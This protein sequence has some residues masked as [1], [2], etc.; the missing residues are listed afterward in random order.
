VK[1]SLA[2][3]R[4]RWQTRVALAVTIESGRIA[5]DLVRRENGGSRVVQSLVLPMGAE[6]IVA[7]PQ[8]AGEEFAAQLRAS[9]IRERR[10][11]VCIPAGWAITTATDLPGISPED[12]RSYLE[13]RAESE[14]P[15]PVADLRLAHCVYLLPD[16]KQRATVV[17]VPAKRIEAVERMLDTAGCRAVSRRGPSGV[18]R[19]WNR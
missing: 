6:A 11:V 3:L 5:V 1:L 17:A 14:F 16:G 12:L 2:V 9:G 8:K 15:V 13:L 10:C 7:D 4:K 18:I 19:S